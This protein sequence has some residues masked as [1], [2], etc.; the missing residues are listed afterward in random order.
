MHVV[1][2]NDEFPGKRMHAFTSFYQAPDN[3]FS[4]TNPCIKGVQWHVGPKPPYPHPR[5][6]KKVIS[7]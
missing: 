3:I 7:L 1:G 4:I 5:S 6:L 2:Q